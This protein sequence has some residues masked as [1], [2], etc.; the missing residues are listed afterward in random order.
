M[1]VLLEA[2]YTKVHLMQPPDSQV[3]QMPNKVIIIRL[4]QQ[5]QFTV[6]LGTLMTAY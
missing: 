5:E 4:Q 6:R 2:L 1:G 3:W